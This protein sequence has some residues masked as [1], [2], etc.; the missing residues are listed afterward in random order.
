MDQSYL[1]GSREGPA[2]ALRRRDNIQNERATRNPRINTLILGQVLIGTNLS[3]SHLKFVD[4]L[5]SVETYR[6]F[7][8]LACHSPL[9]ILRREAEVDAAI[10][11]FG[12]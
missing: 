2:A 6:P 3:Q 11:A 4:F 9:S 10:G 5:N 7:G 8:T 12:L 1:P